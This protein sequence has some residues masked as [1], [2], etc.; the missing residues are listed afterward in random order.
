MA[1]SGVVAFLVM[2]TPTRCTPLLS[3]GGGARV[4]GVD[5]GDSEGGRHDLADADGS[6]A[7]PPR[8]T[9]G[10][11]AA[12]GAGDEEETALREELVL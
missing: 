1:T 7:H 6:L 10:G 8:G 11:G 2:V 12:V 3:Q 4:R 5:G 9:T